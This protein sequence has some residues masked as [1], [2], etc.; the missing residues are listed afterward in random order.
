[1]VVGVCFVRAGSACGGGDVL[2]RHR[3]I[4]ARVRD[5]FDQFA[6]A[7]HQVG[8]RCRLG[9]DASPRSLAATASRSQSEQRA[10][11]HSHSKSFCRTGR[12][13]GGKPCRCQ[14][15]ASPLARTCSLNSG[16]WRY[17]AMTPIQ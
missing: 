15:S 17:G 14:Y 13:C 4:V 10:S 2:G 11:T 1:M 7:F 16:D 5:P 9:A 12:H 8:A 3:V 6:T